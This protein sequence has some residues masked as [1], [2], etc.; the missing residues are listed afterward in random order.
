MHEHSKVV[1]AIVEV[2]QNN[3]IRGEADVYAVCI[4]FILLQESKLLE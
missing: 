1:D 4:T 3:L 2:L